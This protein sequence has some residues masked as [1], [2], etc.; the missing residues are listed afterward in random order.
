MAI[1]LQK[2]QKID[3]TKGRAGLSSLTVGL[4]WDPVTAEKPKGLFGG[5]FGGGGTANI[6]CVNYLIVV[7]V[8]NLKCHNI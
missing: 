6:V 3:L 7:C 1:S 8:C 2:G 4:G 5:L